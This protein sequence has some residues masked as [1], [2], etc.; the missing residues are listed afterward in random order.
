[1]ESV[2][3]AEFRRAGVGKS[4]FAIPLICFALTSN[5]KKPTP[6]KSKVQTASKSKVQT[7]LKPRKIVPKVVPVK[8]P[9]KQEKPNRQV[10][11]L[12]IKKTAEGHTI[13]KKKTNF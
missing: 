1:M 9:I 6:S 13:V 3:A 12:I 5:K 7:V 2:F 8:K 11:P 4:R 10:K